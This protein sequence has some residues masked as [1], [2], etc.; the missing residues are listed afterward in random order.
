MPRKVLHHNP[1][2]TRLDLSMKEDIG[3][4]IRSQKSREQ[5]LAEFSGV[6]INPYFLIF[7]FPLLMIALFCADSYFPDMGPLLSWVVFLVFNLIET[8]LWNNR[9]ERKLEIL[10]ELEKCRIDNVLKDIKNE[11]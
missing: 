4:F 10:Y 3:Q 6:K 1:F 9:Q 11:S 2:K 8:V 7:R 5:L